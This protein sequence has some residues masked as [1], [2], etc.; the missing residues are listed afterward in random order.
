MN[1]LPLDVHVKTAN[2]RV[3]SLILWSA[4]PKP[5]QILLFLVLSAGAA[6]AQT[7]VQAVE[8]QKALVQKYC[9]GCHNDTLKSGGFSWTR[10][11]L[12]HPDQNA[13]AAER[14]METAAGMM[15]PSG[16]PRPDEASLK[17][18]AVSLENRVDEAAASD[19]YVDTPE[20][21]RMNRKEYRNSVR[22]LLG[23]DID[24]S[25][26]LPPD[27]RTGAFDNMAEAL[28]VT[29]ALMQAYIRGCRRHCPAGHRRPAGTGAD[30]PVRRSESESTA[31]CRG[32]PFWN[33]RRDLG[34][35]QFPRRRRICLQAAALVYL[36]GRTDRQGS[37]EFF[38]G[39][40]D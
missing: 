19:P 6:S 12:A 34:D 8:S 39:A 15:P 32:H 4:D 5:A 3:K 37:S 17:Q 22:D 23:V 29:P 40:A 7:N 28:T 10:L 33:P 16:A 26:L 24:V 36:H 13:P 31:S 14:V 20:L 11:D 18:L 35:S 21:R 25:A 30:D 9:T 38:A 2:N 27:A 1:G